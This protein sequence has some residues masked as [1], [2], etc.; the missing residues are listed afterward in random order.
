[1]E[2]FIAMMMVLFLVAFPII[3]AILWTNRRDTEQAVID[4]L[5][6]IDHGTI[7]TGPR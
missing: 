6:G 1:M 3:G 2:L 7:S 4:K 5:K